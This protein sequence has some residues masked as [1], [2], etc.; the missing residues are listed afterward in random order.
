VFVEPGSPKGFRF[1]HSFR[2]WILAKERTEASIIAPCPGHKTCPMANNPESWCH[3][4]QITQRIPSSTFPKRPQ[5]RDTM[6][7]KF[8]YLVVKKGVTPNVTY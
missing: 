7:E 6:N 2:E 5:E 3:F 8:S 4:S 1:I